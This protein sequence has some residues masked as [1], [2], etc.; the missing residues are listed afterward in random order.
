MQLRFIFGVKLSGA[1]IEKSVKVEI[2]L[3]GVYRKKHTDKKAAPF[4]VFCN[5]NKTK[6]V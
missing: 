5:N 2:Y 6:N 1:K 4:R 3:N